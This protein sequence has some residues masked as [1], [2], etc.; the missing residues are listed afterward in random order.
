[1]QDTP[2]EI[3]GCTAIGPYQGRASAAIDGDMELEKALEACQSNPSC[4]GVSSWYIGALWSPVSTTEA[5][6]PD[7]ASYGCLRSERP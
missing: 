7:S 3:Q 5:F 2:I 6:V 1:M 4:M